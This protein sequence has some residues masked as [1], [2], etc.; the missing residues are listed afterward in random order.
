MDVHRPTRSR[1]SEHTNGISSIREEKN[2]IHDYSSP[3]WAA[4]IFVNRGRPKKERIPPRTRAK[5]RPR[6]GP[7]KLFSA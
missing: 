3:F 5:V 6:S 4:A 1:A 2:D 7:K